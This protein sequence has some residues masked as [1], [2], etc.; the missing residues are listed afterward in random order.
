MRHDLDSGPSACCG[1]VQC[2]ASPARDRPCPVIEDARNTFPHGSRDGLQGDVPRRFQ[3][4]RIRYSAD[5][6]GSAATVRNGH[7]RG[8]PA[9]LL[10]YLRWRDA[11]WSTGNCHISRPVTIVLIRQWETNF[12]GPAWLRGF[13]QRPGW[14]VV[15]FSALLGTYSHVLLDSIMHGDMNPF[16]PM[17]VR[18]HLLGYIDAYRLHAICAITGVG[19]TL[20]F[21]AVRYYRS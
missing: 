14:G 21:F 18:N 2:R 12:R 1:S 5:L 6:D 17:T 9:R 16:W 7:G 13:Q 4:D 8:C 20:L 15:C 3:P 10:P 19:A 11:D